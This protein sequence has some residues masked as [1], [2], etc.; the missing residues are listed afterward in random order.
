MGW[1]TGKG[2]KACGFAQVD[3]PGRAVF[4]FQAEASPISLQLIDINEV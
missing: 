1:V 2:E 3:A 4:P